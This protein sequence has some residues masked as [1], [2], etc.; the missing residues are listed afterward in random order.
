MTM[1]DKIVVM[2][3]GKVELIGAPLDLYD[4]P[5]NMFVASFIGSP[6]MN[7]ISGTCLQGDKPGLKLED[8]AVLPLAESPRA[9]SGASVLFGIRPE[10]VVIDELSGVAAEIV[11]VEPTGS[12]THATAIIGKQPVSC[13][14]R[15]R[16]S[17]APG[18]RV[19]LSFA[20]GPNHFFDAATTM[21]M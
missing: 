1:A 10:H 13:V 2:H 17:I 4:R 5:N 21:R 11:T 3:A 14:F 8:G 19:P 6:S 12:E 16:L 9:S 15:T 7:L 20:H 18:D